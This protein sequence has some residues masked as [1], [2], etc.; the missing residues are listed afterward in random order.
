MRPTKKTHFRSFNDIERFSNKDEYFCTSIVFSP[1]TENDHF[2]GCPPYIEIVSIEGCESFFFKVPEII[3]YYGTQHAGYTH[4]G[5]DRREQEGARKL[6]NKLK[7]LLD[8]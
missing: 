5:L 6:S 7:S 4:K 2:D 8:L 3:A 1:D